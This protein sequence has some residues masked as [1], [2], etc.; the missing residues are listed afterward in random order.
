MI[1]SLFGLLAFLG[2]GEGT[3]F[4]QVNSMTGVQTPC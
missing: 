2:V 1:C 4:D 3:N